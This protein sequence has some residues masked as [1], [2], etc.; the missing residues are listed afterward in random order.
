MRFS[1]I[2]VSTVALL[3]GFAMAYPGESNYNL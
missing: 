1:T 3:S 2:A